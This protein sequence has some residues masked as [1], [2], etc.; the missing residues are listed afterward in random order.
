MYER[1]AT[2]GTKTHR[3]EL[4]R[5][6]RSTLGTSSDDAPTVLQ[7][8]RAA[9]ALQRILDAA[10]GGRY[11]LAVVDLHRVGMG[12]LNEA[13]INTSVA[14]EHVRKAHDEGLDRIPFCDRHAKP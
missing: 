2:T 8:L 5:D 7:A 10:S 12:P 13:I 9:S 3:R 4:R 11:G 14:T 1:F 6:V